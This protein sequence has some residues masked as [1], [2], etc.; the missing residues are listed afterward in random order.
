[1]TLSLPT[2]IVFEREEARE[3]CQTTHDFAK[4]VYSRSVTLPPAFLAMG[5]VHSTEHFVVILSGSGWLA[6][7]NPRTV[8]RVEG[9]MVFKGKPG[10]RKAVY[11]ETEMRI[12][13][14]H[15]TDETDIN[16]IEKEVIQ[17]DSDTRGIQEFLLDFVD[18][19]RSRMDAEARA[20]E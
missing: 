17:A 8:K 10:Q 6:T 4:G 3:L 14:F 19:V 9:G 20:L 11:A 1:M 12:M 13:N 15:G 2:V 18:S 5:E 16:L 7:D